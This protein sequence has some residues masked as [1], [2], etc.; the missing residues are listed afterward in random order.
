MLEK[1]L[2]PL[3]N[4]FITVWSRYLKGGNYS[5]I[6]S[7]IWRLARLGQVNAMQVWYDH[8]TIGTDGVIDA[9]VKFYEEE[10]DLHS[11]YLLG[12]YEKNQ[13]DQCF[14]YM[15]LAR[16]Y[17]EIENKLSYG[18]GFM[19]ENL[20]RKPQ[21]WAE[22]YNQQ[23]AIYYIGAINAGF[24]DL[25]E[26]E[27][28]LVMQ[29]LCEI[30][31]SISGWFF[32]D[33]DKSELIEKISAL[34]NIA[35]RDLSKAFSKVRGRTVEEKAKKSPQLAFQLAKCI[36]Y[37]HSKHNALVEEADKIIDSLASREL[38]FKPAWQSER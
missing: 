9:N 4:D 26:E 25:E 31:N 13:P 3:D 19:L 29:S 15:T 5:D 8:N 14:K 38:E 30:M 27:N 16:E 18:K 22:I 2:T 6:K 20:Q 24:D 28:P 11:L 35:V 10:T 12:Q 23:F 17:R 7:D 36:K 32:A 37:F 1:D 34:S 33:P 21:I